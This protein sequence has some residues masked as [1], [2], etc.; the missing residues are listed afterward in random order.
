MLKNNHLN[1]LVSD[2]HHKPYIDNLCLFRALSLHLNRSS[3]L[4][5]NTQSL[6]TKFIEKASYDAEHF[7]GVS[8]PDLHLVEEVIGQNILIYDFETEDGEFI[9][10]LARRSLGKYDKSVK[11]LRYNHH[12]CYVPDLNKFFKAFRCTICDKFFKQ[13]SDLLR[14]MSS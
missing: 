6:F 5:T 10:E 4:E 14:H 7:R 1:C 9:G 8:F 3:D 12:I 13:S 11:L 2:H